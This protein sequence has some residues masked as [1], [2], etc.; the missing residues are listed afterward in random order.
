MDS[1]P[2]LVKWKPLVSGLI[3]LILFFLT[4]NMACD[5]SSSTTA[6][7]TC[8]KQSI[9]NYTVTFNQISAAATLLELP[10]GAKIHH[11]SSVILDFLLKR[12][13]LT[14]LVCR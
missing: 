1:R 7:I 5:V 14:R 8:I 10:M 4:M 9:Q 12:K 13:Q 6:C 3:C 2:K 11:Q